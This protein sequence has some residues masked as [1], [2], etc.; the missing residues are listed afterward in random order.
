[1]RGASSIEEA[2]DKGEPSTYQDGGDDEE[3][4]LPVGPPGIDPT[5]GSPVLEP[6]LG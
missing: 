2:L 4:A 1:M 3:D 5:V 6:L